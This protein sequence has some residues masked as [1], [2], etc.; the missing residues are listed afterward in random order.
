MM[1]TLMAFT[2][3]VMFAL[4]GSKVGS[5]IGQKQF[6]DVGKLCFGFT[7]FYAYLTFAHILTYWY[8]NMP[9]ETSYFHARL[10]EP[11]KSLVIACGLGTFIIPFFSLIPKA[12]KWT[13]WITIPVCCVVLFSQWFVYLLVVM[14]EV[15][16]ASQWSFPWI[17]LGMLSG[18]FGTFLYAFMRMGEKVPMLSIADP[19]LVKSM[20]QH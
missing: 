7:V 2:L 18:F 12:S 3:L 14:P 1:Q 16:P 11:W 17:E 10:V 19:L 6:H 20:H 8:A 15:V 13:P 9:E 4:R 5:Y